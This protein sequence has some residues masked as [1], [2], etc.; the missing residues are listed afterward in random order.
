MREF[1][2]KN[3]SDKIL[4]ADELVKLLQKI[5][6]HYGKP[7]T[8]NSAY[9]T[10]AYNK[11]VGG[12]KYSQHV[13]GK[14]ADIVISGVT[15]YEVAKYAESLG[16]GGIGLYNSFTHVDVRPGKSRWDQRSGKQVIVKT[17]KK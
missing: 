8:I 5:R 13:Q 12:A 6:D 11:K 7:I 15:P 1:R 16:A 14:A 3:G 2:C 10:P 17:F 9:R 4:I